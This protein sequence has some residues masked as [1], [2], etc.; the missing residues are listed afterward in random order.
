VNLPHDPDEPRP[1]EDEDDLPNEDDQELF[2]SELNMERILDYLDLLHAT[3]VEQTGSFEEDNLA[4]NFTLSLDDPPQEFRGFA[5]FVKDRWV[6]VCLLRDWS[7]GIRV[8]FRDRAAEIM[9]TIGLHG[10]SLYFLPDEDTLYMSHRIFSEGLNFDVVR[11]SIW[12]LVSAQSRVAAI[13]ER[14]R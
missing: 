3:D 12:S 6:D 9:N 11:A 2:E 10:I 14:E 13:L 8:K 5:C 4:V 1:F 7:S